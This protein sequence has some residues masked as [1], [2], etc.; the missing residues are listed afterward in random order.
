MVWNAVAPVVAV[1]GERLDRRWGWDRLPLLLGSITL[2]GLRH[3]LRQR[4]LYDPNA[5]NPPP[6]SGERRTP[7]PLSSRSIDGR[8]NDLE[9]PEMGAVGARF[10][11]NGPAFPESEEAIGWPAPREVSRKLLTRREFIPA[12]ELNLLA[13]AW[14]QFEVH[15]WFAHRTEAARHGRTKGEPADPGPPALKVDP[16]SP[17]GSPFYLS[18]Q[19][20]WWD[21]SQLY[22]ADERFAGA[23]RRTREGRKV[24]KDHGKVQVDD[25]LLRTI[26]DY[27]T[28]SDA[29]AEGERKPPPVQNLWLGLALFHTIFA[30]EHN[31]ICDQLHELHPDWSNDRLYDQAR[32]INAAVMAKIHTVEWTPAIIAHPTTEHAIRTT[33]WGVLGQRFRRRGRIGP[34]E[35]LSGIVGST[36]DHDGVPYALTEEFVAVYRMHPLIPDAVTFHR[37]SDHARMDELEGGATVP[38]DELA[39]APG[40]LDRPRERLSQIGQENALYSLAIANPGAITLHNYPA[41]LQRVL[42]LDTGEELDVGELDI[43]RTRECAIPRYNDFRRVFR[44]PPA[45]SFVELADGNVGLAQEISDVYGGELERV[46]LLIGLLAERKPQGFAFSDTAFRVFLLMA[47]RRLR[48]DRFFTD[49]YTEAVYQPEGLEW[50]E[51]ATMTTVLTRCYPSLAPILEHV[52]NAFKPWPTPAQ[53]R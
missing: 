33:W 39:V 27:M 21:A 23:L 46:D 28:P 13:A 11:R 40:A 50:I 36:K 10:G 3:R 53:T 25:E 31:A 1:I 44:L 35:I 47:A 51:R 52:D 4:N 43:R 38:I 41:F 48:S 7:P 9:D 14:V 16:G 29:G 12:T 24:K 6:P 30:H 34:G 37:A 18:D 20:H 45:R 42:R 32:L 17:A 26:E 22:G 2:L 8:D 49:D 5:V 15:D 19:T